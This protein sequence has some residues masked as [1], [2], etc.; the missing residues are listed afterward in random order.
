[1]VEAII[2]GGEGEAVV[3]D[4]KVRAGSLLSQGKVV[5]LYKIEGQELG[6]VGKLKSSAMGRVV[7]VMVR[8]GETIKPGQEVVKFTGGCQHPTIMKDMCAGKAGKM[9]LN[10][11]KMTNVQSV[12][13]T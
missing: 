8:K 2:Y 4:V 11:V 6:Q 5:L 3:A 1:M 9:I 12:G 10:I 13:L 7:E